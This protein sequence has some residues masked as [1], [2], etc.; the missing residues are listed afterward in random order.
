MSRRRF[1]ALEPAELPS[2]TP[3]VMVLGCSRGRSYHKRQRD[4]RM[5]G[6]GA[7]VVTGNASVRTDWIVPSAR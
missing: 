6:Q 7:V 2:S 3:P 1:G 4:P 5:M